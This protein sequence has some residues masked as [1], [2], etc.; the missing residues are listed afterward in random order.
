[1]Q[2]L[3]PAEGGGPE[4]GLPLWCPGQWAGE[5]GLTRVSMSGAEAGGKNWSLL[6]PGPGLPEHGPIHV[7]IAWLSP[8]PPVRVVS[9]PPLLPAA[10]RLPPGGREPWKGNGEHPE[11]RLFQRC[12]LQLLAPLTAGRGQ[13]GGRGGGTAETQGKGRGT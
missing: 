3:W 6:P 1:M 8:Q 12:Y 4:P 13:R 9:H 7:P 5:P 11:L 10:V 2:P